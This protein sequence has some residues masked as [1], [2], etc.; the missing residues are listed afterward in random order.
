MKEKYWY[1]SIIDESLI[2]NFIYT[3]YTSVKNVK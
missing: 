3:W 2:R 1:E